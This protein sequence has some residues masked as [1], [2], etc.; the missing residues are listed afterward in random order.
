MEIEKLQDKPNF[1][2]WAGKVIDGSHSDKNLKAHARI[3]PLLLTA[4]DQ[5]SLKEVEEIKFT[6]INEGYVNTVLLKDIV[7]KTDFSQNWDIKYL[8][9]LQSINIKEL[10]ILPIF[11]F[12]PKGR[13]NNLGPHSE[14]ND[15]ITV[16]LKHP[17]F[18]LQAG[19]FHYE[20]SDMLHQV[21]AIP[22]RILV[23]NFTDHKAKV[24]DFVNSFLPFV[25]RLLLLN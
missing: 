17:V 13:G 11:Y 4:Y 10:F 23:N 15:L 22:R 9:F 21:R 5:D 12:P 7:T 8:L 16:G 20:N 3:V 2:S 6:L 14:L 25:A 24:V 1:L 18:V 19:V